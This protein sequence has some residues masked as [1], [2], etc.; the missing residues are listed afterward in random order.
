VRTLLIHPRFP[1]CFWNP[2][3]V[4]TLTGRRAAAP[5][6]G[7]LTVAA[8]LPAE[9]KLRLRDLNADD[10][11]EADWEWA[12]LVLVSGMIAQRPG[13]LDI[14]R[15]AGRRGK[16]VVA[17]GFYPWAV[18]DE[19]LAAGADL[20][21][22]GEAEVLMPHLLD[23]LARGRR[24]PLRA[25]AHA[26]MRSS[27]VPR[28]DLLRLDAY[29]QM[30]VETARG[31]PQRCEFCD[32]IHLLGRTPRHKSTAQVLS[33]L[34]ALRRLG[35]RGHVFIADDNFIGDPRRAKRL[36]REIIRWQVGHEK[37][38]S[39]G[40]QASLTLGEDLELMDLMT[41]SNVGTV[42]VGLESP[43]AH[44]LRLAGKPQNLRRDA[45]ETLR[46]MNRN[47]VSVIGSFIIGLDGEAP[48]VDRRIAEL[49]E[50]ADLPLSMINMLRAP[51]GSQ[52]WHRL[53]REGR[54]DEDL[55]AQAESLLPQ[56][57]FVP[58]RPRAEIEREYVAI[59]ET[60]YDPSRFLARAYRSHLAMRPTR[61]ASARVRG[62]PCPAKH[63]PGR[64][65]FHPRGAL[66]L[67]WWGVRSPRRR[68]FWAQLTALQRRNP[69]RVFS[70]LATL[71]FG[72]DMRRIRNRILGAAGR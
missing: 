7:L 39:F 55:D 61:A 10:L 40:A 37:P 64:R 26:D 12:Q 13:L 43:D 34:E 59:W 49:V 23:A 25:E 27:P 42:F 53:K 52:L 14:V 67:W 3:A 4:A 30:A 45:G 69:S 57:N 18:P 8:L 62:E 1:E 50:A 35:Y 48:G 17:G 66:L 54:L 5:P 71:A 2:P 28:F 68:Q 72:E 58:A 9:W 31:C 24:G 15:E 32:V 51:P 44:A 70:Y 36:L 47:G 21:A 29:R 22:V 41:T 60:L 20:V 38:F 65:R 33:E 63:R 16:T 6:L 11:A 19:V 56:P 46:V